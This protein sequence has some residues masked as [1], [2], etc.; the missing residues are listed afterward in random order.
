MEIITPQS[1]WK[2]F[3]ADGDFETVVVSSNEG[4]VYRTTEMYFSGSSTG[5]GVVRIFATMYMPSV[6]APG[7]AAILFFDD[8][9]SAGSLPFIEALVSRGFA[10]LRV[11]YAGAGG[12]GR[13]T[14][15]P[16]S[17]YRGNYGHENELPDDLKV[18]SAYIWT[19]VGLRAAKFLRES[20]GIDRERIGVLGIG[21]GGALA[22]R[23]AMLC[24]FKAGM[25]LFG[26]GIIDDRLKPDPLYL[27]YKAAL[28]V[29]SYAP[30]SRCPMLLQTTSNE[31]NSSLDYM[32]ELYD[33][34][35]TARFSI[36]ERGNR[37]IITSQKK[38]Y[39]YW[40][41]RQLFGE[42][43]VPDPP[44]LTARES[45][46]GLYYDIETDV[47]H[48]LVTVELFVSQG[49][50]KAAYRNWS[51]VKM[52]KAGEGKYLAKVDVYDGSEPVYAFVS[53]K[54]R[55]SLYVT[56]PLVMRI[57]KLMGVTAKPRR[58]RLIYESGMVKD[59]FSV[60]DDYDLSYGVEKLAVEK[61]PFGI[62]GI[63]SATHRIVT[64]KLGDYQYRGE[65]DNVLQLLIYVERLSAVNFMIMDWEGRHYYCTREYGPADEWVTV[66][67]SP[68]DFR[69]DNQPFVSW[70]EAAAIGVNSDCRLLIN[71]VL[72]V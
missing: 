48:E 21:E 61:G 4:S 41:L 31:S 70:N 28:D 32:A 23:L 30:F 22:W 6:G 37:A 24:D 52:D 40:F 55:H 68:G 67:L 34:S 51:S 46:G 47:K 14:L 64:F 42:G 1:L 49:K 53:V 65:R 33:G 45:G 26:G 2:D 7:L 35:R 71:T 12:S 43:Y 54:Y 8:A 15:Y 50:L 57:P 58:S 9:A 62:E 10:V 25:S 44:K 66:S 36:G 11:D 13:Y 27:T 16:D 19:A 29:R 17:L 63:S 72:W 69:R 60:P 18:S 38:N 5:D 59:D 39:L 20:E 3:C 56:S